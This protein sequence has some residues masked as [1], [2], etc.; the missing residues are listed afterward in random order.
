MAPTACSHRMWYGN[1]GSIA[2]GLP[3]VGSPEERERHGESKHVSIRIGRVGE[4]VMI[5]MG[6]GET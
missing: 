6:M 1:R 2:D 5:S 4:A 3:L